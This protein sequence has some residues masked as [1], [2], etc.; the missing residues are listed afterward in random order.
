MK[1]KSQN[2][3]KCECEHSISRHYHG[4]CSAMDDWKPEKEARCRC[5]RFK[6][7]KRVAKAERT[8]KSGNWKFPAIRKRM[9]KK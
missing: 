6:E 2:Y 3:K 5:E 7:K 9:Y 4:I 8:N 1:A